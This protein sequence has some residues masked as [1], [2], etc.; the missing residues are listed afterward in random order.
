MLRFEYSSWIDAPVAAVFGFHERPD[1]LEL[2]TPPWPPVTVLRRPASLACGSIAELRIGIW[3][4]SVHWVAHHIAYEPARLFVDEQR[5]GPFAAWVHAHR[6]APESGGTRL[7][8]SVEFA[9]Y[10]GATAEK[11]LGWLVRRQLR[12]MFRY[13]HGVTRRHC[14]AREAS[15]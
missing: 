3:P 14:E 10:G 6:F 11:A 15:Q 13:R 12:G 7:L 2:L 5:S 9:L 8:D 1:A 4:L